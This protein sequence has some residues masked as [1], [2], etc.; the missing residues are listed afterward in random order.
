MLIHTS[1]MI[2]QGPRRLHALASNKHKGAA[3]EGWRARNSRPHGQSTDEESRGLGSAG[4]KG[5][6]SEGGPSKSSESKS[7]LADN[8]CW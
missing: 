1:I 6:H 7:V 5:G 4:T 2:R 3:R 8:R